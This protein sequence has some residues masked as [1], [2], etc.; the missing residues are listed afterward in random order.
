MDFAGPG[1]RFYSSHSEGH[2]FSPHRAP[3]KKLKML[4]GL[5]IKIVL[6][7]RGLKECN[8]H[9][10]SVIQN[11]SLLLSSDYKRNYCSQCDINRKK[12]GISN[13]FIWIMYILRIKKTFHYG[14]QFTVYVTYY[15]DC[16]TL[17]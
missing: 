1:N 9:V 11:F 17:L 10:I 13:A 4:R 14:K 12:T 3:H 7:F 5:H 15:V 2:V 16:T 8:V 6:I